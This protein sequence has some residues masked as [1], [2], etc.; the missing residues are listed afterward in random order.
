[1][2]R[3]HRI[4]APGPG[5]RL[6]SRTD[7]GGAPPNVAPTDWYRPSQ[8]PQDPAVDPR[9]PFGSESDDAGYSHGWANCTMASGAMALD[10]HTLGRLQKWG[11]ELRHAPGQPDMTGGTDLHDLSAA[12]D[13]FG[14]SLGIGSG[15]GW[16]AVVNE[17][18]KGRAIVL[19]GRGDV[20]GSGT[21]AGN[22]CICVLPES[23][24]GRWLQ[25]D[26]LCSGPELVS[27]DALRA[28]AQ[29]LEPGILFGYSAAHK[30]APV[31][32][33]VMYNVAPLTTHRDAV[34]R[35]GAVLYADSAMTKRHSVTSGDTPLG[36]AGSTSEAH[37]VVNAGN[38]NYVHRNDVLR[39][40]N[41]D[42]TFS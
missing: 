29:L 4:L 36:F 20:P 37:V 40:V 15:A 10:F 5:D 25:A 31:G 19:M 30:P 38:T 21:F 35:G 24:G 33:D 6:P 11:G 22:H 9:E 8:R 16:D 2:R 13:Y 41:N 28:W 12:W 3:R 34:V 42:R 27:P 7:A 23:S 32:E 39:I 1:M 14:E 26:P 17:R 18:A